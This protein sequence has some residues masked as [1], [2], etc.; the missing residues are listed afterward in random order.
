MLNPS[1][2]YNTGENSPTPGT[3]RSNLVRQL[4]TI[5]VATPSNCRRSTAP[6]DLILLSCSRMAPSDLILLSCSQVTP[7]KLI[8]PHCHTRANEF[9]AK[10]AHVS[11][12]PRKE[13]SPEGNTVLP[14]SDSI[15]SPTPP[16]ELILSHSHTKAKDF[17]TSPPL[18]KLHVRRCRCQLTEH[19]GPNDLSVSYRTSWG[20]LPQTPVFS[21]RSAR[22]H[23]YSSM[24]AL[25]NIQVRTT[26]Q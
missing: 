13:G 3:L 17:L 25:T 8:L 12:F 21:L 18:L 14:P 5:W 15:C 6:P 10:P 26:C 23:W 20:I 16:S 22:C 24:A 7:L 9:R 1:S 2:F 11:G 19:P 4:R